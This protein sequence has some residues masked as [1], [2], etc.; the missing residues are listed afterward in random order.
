MTSSPAEV[1]VTGA[2]GFIAEHCILELLRAGYRVRGTVRSQTKAARL[3]ETIARHTNAGDR[4]ALVQADL[5]VD[6][7]WD[8]A[9]R[10][11]DY[12]LHVASPFPSALP[13]HEDELIVP[14]RDG[15]LRILRAAAKAGVRRVVLTSSL[16]AVVC[17]HARDGSEVYDETSWS[18]V[19]KDIGAY[20]KSK[21]LAEQAAWDFVR[22]L[23]ADRPLEL[24]TVNPGLVLGPVLDGSF[25]TSASVVRDLLRGSMPGCPP[26]GWAMV[27][28]RDVAKMHLLALTTKEA[29]GQRFVCAGEH[30]WLIDVARV[31]ERHFGPKGYKVPTRELPGWMV[32]VVAL[33]DKKVRLVVNEV[34]RRQDVTHER[35]RR[36]FG[37]EPRGLE[38][39][40]VATG[41]SLI[42]YGAV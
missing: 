4:L 37:W 12:V 26:L 42:Q 8:D 1:V 21:T 7:G 15:A 3:R 32:R 36:V 27:D 39:M 6:E 14:A 40:V 2:T 31:L 30:A 13:R 38:E 33:F 16:A 22:S 10:G 24:V 19:S 41:E 28:V 18:D 17:G 11:A 9:L 23:P 34:G 20:E 5:E 25:G 29:A 35:A